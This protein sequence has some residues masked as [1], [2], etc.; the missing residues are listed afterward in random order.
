MSDFFR[1]FRVSADLEKTPG[2]DIAGNSADQQDQPLLQRGIGVW[3]GSKNGRNG[4]IGFL[5]YQIRG[6]DIGFGFFENAFS[7]IKRDNFHNSNFKF[8]TIEQEIYF[9]HSNR[10]SRDDHLLPILTGYVLT[11][12]AMTQQ[13]Q[14]HAG[15]IAIYPIENPAATKNHWNLLFKNDSAVPGLCT[16]AFDA[17]ER[18]PGN[19]TNRAR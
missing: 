3:Q 12:S 19:L 9:S 2:N 8:N 14:K 1:F 4:M 5:R 13:S 17:V 16:D 10:V 18:I 6:L 11:A 15:I 7:R